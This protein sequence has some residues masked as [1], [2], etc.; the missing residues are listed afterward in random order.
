MKA[1]L[2][3]MLIPVYCYCNSDASISN[4][5]VDQSTVELVLQSEPGKTYTLM[6][7]PDLDVWEESDVFVTDST[8][9]TIALARTTEPVEFY[10]FSESPTSPLIQ[11]TLT[12]LITLK[13]ADFNEGGVYNGLIKSSRRINV[14]GFNPADESV[15]YMVYGDTGET[16][17]DESGN[18]AYIY[19]TEHYK[20]GAD[21]V[22]IL[23]GSQE[24]LGSS[25]YLPNPVTSSYGGKFESLFIGNKLYYTSNSGPVLNCLNFSNNA[26][27]SSLGAPFLFNGNEYV[28]KG[29]NYAL[30]TNGEKFALEVENKT[31]SLNPDRH[32]FAVFNS[33]L[34]LINVCS[35]PY[36][37]EYGQH[38]SS[39]DWGK[40]YVVFVGDYLYVIGNLGY[41]YTDY[42]AS[43]SGCAIRRLNINDGSYETFIILD[44]PNDPE[45]GWQLFKFNNN[46][47][48]YG[49]QD[50]KT[51][52]DFR[53]SFF[54]KTDLNC[55][56]LWTQYKDYEA[57]W[58]H[59]Y[60]LFA[61]RQDSLTLLNIDYYASRTH[62][63]HV[64]E[65]GDL[66]IQGTGLRSTFFPSNGGNIF[67]TD[68]EYSEPTIFM[69]DLA[70]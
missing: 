10:A 47:L 60:H 4:I 27:H 53:H 68:N 57:N 28:P 45:V 51:S 26:T 24:S 32:Y 42:N 65:S 44:N 43:E 2:L 7:S 33:D 56:P 15:Y 52:D 62:F 6:T 31:E 50:T 30:L 55:L 17:F 69:I 63:L 54:I 61:T 39:Q 23:V 12:E 48:A 3:L 40:N 13:K 22:P 21:G 58:Q 20:V 66:S 14:L 59:S 67:G 18:R 38:F 16:G 1:V 35:Y 9:E 46:L 19:I 41:N 37:D 29:Y 36:Y 5:L 70:D 49:Y 64:G 25:G 11:G 8:N 34:S